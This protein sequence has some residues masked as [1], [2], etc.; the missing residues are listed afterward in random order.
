MRTVRIQNL[1]AMAEPAAAVAPPVAADVGAGGTPLA[2]GPD[3]DGLVE[4]QALEIALLQARLQHLELVVETARSL[5]GS[6]QERLLRRLHDAPREIA[7]L[8]GQLRRIDPQG[9]W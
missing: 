7:A 3:R 1:K 4:R 8:T 6:N 5:M 9:A 2:S